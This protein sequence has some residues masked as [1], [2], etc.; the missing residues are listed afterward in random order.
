MTIAN[1]ATERCTAF[2][3]ALDQ[4]I[5]NQEE[6]LMTNLCKEY[7][8][9]TELIKVM[10]ERNVLIQVEGTKIFKWNKSFDLE[11]DFKFWAFKFIDDIRDFRSKYD[12]TRLAKRKEQRRQEKIS[13]DK[14][15]LAGEK[16]RRET[17]KPI[18]SDALDPKRN[19]FHRPSIRPA[20]A[21]QQPGL[22]PIQNANETQVIYTS[23]VLLHLKHMK[24]DRVFTFKFDCVM[25]KDV[26]AL[27]FEQFNE[28]EVAIGVISN[29]QTNALV[30][31]PYQK[32]YYI[33]KK[34][35][36]HTINP[37]SQTVEFKLAE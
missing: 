1:S 34:F 25:F 5:K 8:L 13:A 15:K 32:L 3:K 16:L 6:I 4:K 19:Q 18:T 36:Q 2:L 26:E 31:V 33:D 11:S 22:K 35:V 28:N 37:I 27:V 9:Q 23:G 29:G 12:K 14:M 20:V 7:S 30:T 17:F 21:P 10:K 24:F